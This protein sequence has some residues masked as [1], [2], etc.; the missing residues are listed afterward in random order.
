MKTL[1][2]KISVNDEGV[3][4]IRVRD[5]EAKSFINRGWNFIAKWAWKK[6]KAPDDPSKEQKRMGVRILPEETLKEML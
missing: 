3:S 2:K 6:A 5:E 1:V 4:I